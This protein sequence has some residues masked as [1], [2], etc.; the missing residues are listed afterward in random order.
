LSEELRLQ[1]LFAFFAVLLI[2]HGIILSPLVEDVAFKKR[3][4]SWFNWGTGFAFAFGLWWALRQTWLLLILLPN[5]V[6]TGYWLSRTI[7]VCGSCGRVNYNDTWWFGRM[8][9]CQKCGSR[10]DREG[11]DDL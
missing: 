5:A 6:L 9:Y 10:L 4:S 11:T 2:S 1:I 7:K 3:Y 8:L